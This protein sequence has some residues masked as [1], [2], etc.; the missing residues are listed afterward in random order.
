M[1]KMKFLKN[2]QKT[3]NFNILKNGIKSLKFTKN[4]NH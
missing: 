3:L 2:K 1:L 4:V